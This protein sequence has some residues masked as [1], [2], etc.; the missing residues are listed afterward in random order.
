MSMTVTFVTVPFYVSHPTNLLV[1][2]YLLSLS[3][4]KASAA[5]RS[6]HCSKAVTSWSSSISGG[7]DPRSVSSFPRSSLHHHQR[8]L[9]HRPQST[10]PS[11]AYS[12]A[13][14]PVSTSVTS[15]VRYSGALAG[16]LWWVLKWRDAGEGWRASLTCTAGTCGQ[17][18]GKICIH[19]TVERTKAQ[20]DIYYHENLTQMM[21]AHIKD[22][23]PRT[24]V[25]LIYSPWLN[26]KASSFLSSSLWILLLAP[27]SFPSLSIINNCF[28]HRSF[29]SFN[30]LI[31]PSLLRII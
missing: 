22:R 20:S 6:L 27:R 9:H 5:A 30:F 7:Q 28:H 3:F 16:L 23:F 14:I 31:F 10:H 1:L 17:M 18:K 21:S 2:S 26:M 15:V 19:D 4:I 25:H 29:H 8:H 24:S 13:I 12:A 11:H